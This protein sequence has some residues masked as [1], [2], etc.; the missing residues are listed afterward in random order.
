MAGIAAVV[1]A[2]AWPRAVASIRYL[3]VEHA[4]QDYYRTLHI[5]TERLPVLIR[6]AEQAIGYQDHHRFHDGL[7]LLHYLRAL[8]I[9]TPA[10]E[11]I[12]EYRAAEAAAAEGLQRNPA[13]PSAW[14]RMA[15]IR[16]I[17]RDEPEDVIEPWKM[18]VFTGRMDYGLILQRVEV[19]LA[20]RQELE[21]EGTAM[22]RDQLLLAW[23]MQPGSLMQLLS[24][25]DDGLTGTRALI[26]ATH[27]AALTEMEAWL[28]RLR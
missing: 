20:Y 1:L 9:Y 2:L 18:S 10:L 19:G 21:E 7:S 6:F 23:R 27:P 22:L 28:E 11:R 17:L 3:P 12:A 25:Q 8:D 5:P 4:L 15:Y 24:R 26:A 16:W 14:L 13:Q